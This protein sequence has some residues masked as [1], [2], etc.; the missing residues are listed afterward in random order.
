MNIPSSFD[1]YIL[2]HKRTE[3]L[4]SILKYKRNPQCINTKLYKQILSTTLIISIPDKIILSTGFLTVSIKF[5]ETFFSVYIKTTTT[6]TKYY[7][8]Y[9]ILHDYHE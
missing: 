9:L 2:S 8:V 1:I 3:L 7:Y 4:R 5:S 6:T